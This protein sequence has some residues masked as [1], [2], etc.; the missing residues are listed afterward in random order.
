MD[1]HA[2]THVLP[3]LDDAIK[4]IYSY[5]S[6][7]T[8]KNAFING[9]NILIIN[10]LRTIILT[11]EQI[12]E[13]ITIAFMNGNKFIIKTLINIYKIN[14]Y[15]INNPLIINIIAKISVIRNDIDTLKYIT[16]LHIIDE[17]HTPLDMM[18]Y[19]ALCTYAVKYH[20]AYILEY[21]L[22]LPDNDTMYQQFIVNNL[23]ATL[24]RNIIHI[25]EMYSVHSI[26]VKIMRLTDNENDKLIQENIIDEFQTGMITDPNELQ[27]IDMIK[28]SLS[29]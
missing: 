1:T 23:T 2:I 4:Y 19:I 25:G 11:K 12:E 10:I 29:Q 14:L 22:Y 8:L 5:Y 9:N 17:N 13:C 7:D 21:L 28:Q 20:R 15:Y 3:S 27:I 18:A 26:K 24:A 16:S 6:Y